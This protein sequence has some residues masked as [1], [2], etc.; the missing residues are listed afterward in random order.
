M[1][2]VRSRREVT[3]GHYNLHALNAFEQIARVASVV[4]KLPRNGAVFFG[5]ELGE[6]RTTYGDLLRGAVRLSCSIPIVMGAP[7]PLG[8][9]TMVIP[10]RVAF[11]SCTKRGTLFSNKTAW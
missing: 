7:Y 2:P 4:D 9:T 6:K 8:F 10:M 1:I 3:N 11:P 5:L